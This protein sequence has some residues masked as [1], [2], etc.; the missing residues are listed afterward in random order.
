MAEQLDEFHL[1]AWRAF[2]NAHAAVIDRIEREMDAAGVLPL[3]SYDVL[4]ALSE[5]PG[6]RLRLH[7]LASRIV[8]SRSTLTRV[9]DRLETAG[10]LARERAATDRRGAYAV[11]TEQGREALRTAWP[12]YAQ[13]IRE[14][15]AR[16]LDEDEV[17]VLTAALGRI[18]RA[19]RSPVDASGAAQ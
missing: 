19:A 7:E 6:R 17:H 12:V 9:V 15:F 3:G 1:A 4:V 18:D 5:A 8:L 13:G 16:H 2:L 11:L 14:H 10:L